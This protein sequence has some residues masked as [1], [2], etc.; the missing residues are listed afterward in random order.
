MANNNWET[1]GKSILDIVQSAVESQDFQQLNQTISSAFNTA[2]KEV[3]KGIRNV[4]NIINQE[5][6]KTPKILYKDTTKYTI[7]SIIMMIFGYLFGTSFMIAF[8]GILCGTM[9]FSLG[10]ASTVLLIVFGVL[11][12][13]FLLLAYKGTSLLTRVKRFK[14]YVHGLAGKTSISLEQLSYEVHK[15]IKFVRKDLMNMIDNGWFF[16]G[17]LDREAN[18]LMVTHEDYHEYLKTIQKQ[19]SYDEFSDDVKDVLVLGEKYI[20]EIRQCNDDIDDVE[21]SKKI[22]KMEVLVQ[23]IFKHIENHPENIK[24]LRKFM[25]YY[26][27]TTIKLLKAYEELEEQPIQGENI[28][29]SKKE[30]E[31]TFDTINYAFEKLLDDLFQETAWDVSSD[32]TVLETLLAKEGLTKK[33]L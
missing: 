16:E 23:K 22:S 24:D 30:I 15:T 19:S 10:T 5:R 31:K 6:A 21:M 14:K 28:N 1:L 9:F 11:A 8:L 29:N 25:K 18:I 17:H 32:A 2:A 7:S 4:E 20:L 12:F 26:L 27:P 13:L 3:E 33:Q